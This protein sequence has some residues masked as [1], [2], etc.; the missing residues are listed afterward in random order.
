M[1]R[2]TRQAVRDILFVVGEASGDLHAGKVAEALRG[3][4]PAV[5]MKGIGGG[6]MRD[7]GVEILEPV[8]NL[9]VMG[10]V[11]VLRHLPKHRALLDML[12]TH[13]SSGRIGLVVLLDYPGFNARVAEAA[14]AAGIPVLYYITP[15]VWAWGANRLPKLAR[16]ITKAACILSFEPPLLRAHGIDATFVGHPLLDRAQ[17]LP[18]PAEAR[19]TLGLRDDAPVLAVFPGSRRAELS[20]HLAPFVATAKELQRRIPSLQVVFSVAP[21][22]EILERDCPFP[23]VHSQSFTVL[24][25]ATA[26]LLKSG[27]T[28]LEAAVA[29][30]PHVMG[31]RTSAVEFAIAKRLVKIPHI[32]LVNI[33]GQREV[34]RE[35]VQDA[36]RP[37]AV[38]DALMPLLQTDSA[39]RARAVSELAEVR[40]RLGTPGAAKRVA[41]M[42]LDLLQG[43]P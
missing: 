20:R 1:P 5:R 13:L 9:A 6:H 41:A 31:Y 26:G 17:T 23:R 3:L 8:E 30:L 34:S 37:P 27:T 32:G 14:R 35:F 4:A 18:T 12:R 39:A 16:V 10:F 7:A 19:A 22:V 2:P 21:T 42:A 40:E 11:G 25:A 38:A 29:G 15:Q 33:V 36:F 24:R 28:T 43:A